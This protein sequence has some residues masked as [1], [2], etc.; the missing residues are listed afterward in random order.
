MFLSANANIYVHFL[1]VLMALSPHYGSYF[2][3]SWLT[4]WVLI[5]CQ[6]L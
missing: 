3:M 5:G 6:S 4:W 1:L 2:P